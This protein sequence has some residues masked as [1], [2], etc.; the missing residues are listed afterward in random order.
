V[1]VVKLVQNN[2]RIN[3]MMAARNQLDIT[4]YSDTLKPVYTDPA[5]INQILNNLL[6]NAI[7]FSKEGQSI[8]VYV[9][10]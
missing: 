6:S 8:E 7:K 2:I 9:S 10:D 5:K 3:K 4:F 1:D